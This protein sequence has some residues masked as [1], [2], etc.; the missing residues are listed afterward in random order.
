MEIMPER[1][2]TGLSGR[3]VWNLK[4]DPVL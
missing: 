4:K 3:G 1:V 2:K